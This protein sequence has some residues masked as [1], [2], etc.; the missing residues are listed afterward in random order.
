MFPHI[1]NACDNTGIYSSMI[2][3]KR[4]K[5]KAAPPAK[6]FPSGEHRD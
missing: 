2:L 6:V 4:I 5:E 3:Q 1:K